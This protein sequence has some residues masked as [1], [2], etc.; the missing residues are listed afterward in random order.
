MAMKLPEHL[1]RFWMPAMLSAWA[2]CELLPMS[3]SRWWLAAPWPVALILGGLGGLAYAGVRS[4][5]LL[6]RAS[7][8]A[9][10]QKFL[11]WAQPVCTLLA[12][13]LLL[14]AADRL[15][16]WMRG[17]AMDQIV[18]VQRTYC[19]ASRGRSPTN[20]RMA[21][22]DGR[23]CFDTHGRSVGHIQIAKNSVDPSVAIGDPA[24]AQWRSYPSLLGGSK[25]YYKVIAVQH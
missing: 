24:Q 5:H 9:Q 7:D 11:H 2:I 4:R 1:H 18:S 23:W 13:L 6:Q 17:P 21:E 22:R 12:C 14:M 15:M 3:T 20:N 16:A 10:L 19:I 8:A 25:A